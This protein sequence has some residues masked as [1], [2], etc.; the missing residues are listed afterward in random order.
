MTTICRFRSYP[1]DKWTDEV[2]GYPAT[3]ERAASERDT[4]PPAPKRPPTSVM[5]EARRQR[6]DAIIAAARNLGAGGQLFTPNAVAAACGC[7][8]HQVSIELSRAGV[9]RFV[10]RT[11]RNAS[12]RER[13]YWQLCE[14]EQP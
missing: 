12:H 3:I 4:P 8:L 14:E 10:R 11:A 5:S 2:I 7:R 1:G 6:A 13:R 9:A